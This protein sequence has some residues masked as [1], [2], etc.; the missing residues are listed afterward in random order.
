M[1]SIQQ[2]L[3]ELEKSDQ[4]RALALECY[5]AAINNMAHYTVELDDTITAPH[6]KYLTALAKE[7]AE[8]PPD[9]LVESRSTLRGLL[10]EYRDRAMQYLSGLRGQLSATA[11]ALQEMVEAFSDCD[12]DHTSVLRTSLSRLREVAKSPEASAVGPILTAVADGIDESLE[13]LR[14]QHQFTIS[15]FQSELRLLHA[16]IDSMETAAAIDEATKFSNRRFISE[17]LESLPSEGTAVLILK[18]YGLAQT[19]ARYGPAVA[20]NLVAT[21]G[22][23]LR[24]SL[25]KTAVVGRWNEQEFVAVLPAVKPADAVSSQRMAEHLSPPYAIMLGGK[26]VRISLEVTA[27]YLAAAGNSPAEILARVT[28]AFA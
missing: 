5:L 7:L 17:Y 18:L 22:R 12:A 3:S 11:Q 9:L 2:N 6:R 19:R 16:R 14:K 20:E 27:E 24:N 21:F 10:R 26:V 23:R 4:L 1:I 13:Q 15:Q 28:A 25:P 8:A